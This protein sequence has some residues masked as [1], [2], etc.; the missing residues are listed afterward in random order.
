MTDDGD[1]YWCL[2]HERVEQGPGCKPSDRMGPYP[3]RTDAENWRQKVAERNAAWD[4]ED[5]S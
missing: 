2:R 5:E 1:W 3:T 4:A